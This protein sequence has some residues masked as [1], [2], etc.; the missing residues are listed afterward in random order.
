VHDQTGSYNTA[1]L[2]FGLCIVGAVIMILLVRPPAA[3]EPPRA[4][5]RGGAQQPA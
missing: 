2:A 5:L 4:I 3:P 1:F